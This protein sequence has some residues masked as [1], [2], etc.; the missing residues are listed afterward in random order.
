[1]DNEEAEAL[2]DEIGHRLMADPEYPTNPTLIYVQI[3]DY[4]ISQSIYKDLGNQMLFRWPLSRR[5]PDALC[6]LWDLWD[7]DHRWSELEYVLRDGVFEIFYFY[8]TD[9]D[10]DEDL[11][12]RRERSV[13]RHFGDK[14]I[15]Y[16]PLT[17][18]DPEFY[19]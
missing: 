7:G 3:I 11:H 8:P 16:P 19:E 9:I 17:D 12:D 13:R 14:P 18:D 1:M 5:L 15:I 10:P 4:A 6:D 2:L